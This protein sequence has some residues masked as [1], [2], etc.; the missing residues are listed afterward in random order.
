MKR[1]LAVLCFMSFCHA[2]TVRHVVVIGSGLAGLSA[3]IQACEDGGDAIKVFL[4]EKET[5]IGGNS[6]KASS[7]INATLTSTQEK[8]GIHDS[9]DIFRDDTVKSARV[10]SSNKLIDILVE[11]SAS[12]HRF[13]ADKGVNLDLVAKT[14]GH[15]AARTHRAQHEENDSVTTIGMDIIEALKKYIEEHTKIQIMTRRHVKKLLYKDDDKVYGVEYCDEGS[16][17]THELQADAVILAT[18]G[19]CGQVGQGSLL[20]KVRADLVEFGTTNGSCASGEGI[21]LAEELGATL[22]DMDKVQIHPT[23]LVHPDNPDERSKFLAPESL[24]AAGGILLNA[25]GKR[26]V[27][28]LGTRDEVT[29]AMLNEKGGPETA[30]LVLNEDAAEL[31]QKPVLEYYIEKGFVRVVHGAQQLAD[32]IKTRTENIIETFSSYAECAKKK[33]DGFGKTTFPVT[34]SVDELLYVM[35]VTPCVHYTMGGVKFDCEAR[36]LR[37]DGPIKNLFAAGEVTGGL[38]GENRLCGNS[39]LECVVFGRIAGKNAVVIHD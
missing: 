10:Q 34:F 35:T 33:L 2:S 8:N 26:F 38:H 19:F 1:L 14:G 23:G 21:R 36:V 37:A 31:F 29:C 27:N 18:G 32:V 17:D 6:I 4:L 16:K 15:S 7:G 28:E 30:H 20:H 12:A 3:A 13:L 11:Q 39:L 5:R 24:R 22:V 9:V 25:D